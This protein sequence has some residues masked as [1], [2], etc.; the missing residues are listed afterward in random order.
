[1][2]LQEKLT[3]AVGAAWADRQGLRLV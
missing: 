2:H 3:H 1:V